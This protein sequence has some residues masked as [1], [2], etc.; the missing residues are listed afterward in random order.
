LCKKIVLRLCTGSAYLR[1]AE[2]MAQVG[3]KIDAGLCSRCRHAREI[4]SDRGS[5]F[6]MCQFSAIDP[7]FPKYPRLPVLSCTAYSPGS[8]SPPDA[9]S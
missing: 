7:S 9:S 6:I 3:G 4:A 2:I 8:E 1:Y 5:V